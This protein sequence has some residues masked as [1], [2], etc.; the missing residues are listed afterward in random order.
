[1][2]EDL[3][4][5]LFAANLG[6]LDL[7]SI[8]IG[9][10]LG[11]YRSLA[12][13]GPATPTE[14]ATR[15]G[16]HERYAREWLEQQAATAILTVDDPGGDA[17]E[18]RYALPSAHADLLLNKDNLDFAIGA[19]L[20]GALVAASSA[21]PQVLDAFRTGGGVPWGAYGSRLRDGEANF[22]RGLYL[23]VLCQ[24]YFPL[25]PDAHERLRSQPPARVADLGCGSGWS[26]IAIARGYPGCLVD[27]FDLD[28]ASVSLARKNASEAGVSDRVRFE[29][30]DASDPSLGAAPA[31]RGAYDVVTIF[32]ALHDMSGPV[33]ALVN[34]R[35]MLA[36]G[37]TAIVMDERVGEEFT[38]PADDV[39]RFMYGWSILVCLP[40]GMSQPP[41][42]GTGT[43][44]R[45]ATLRKYAAKAGFRDVVILPIENDFFRFYRLVA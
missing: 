2:G 6:A 42:A 34:V 44:M 41:A 14:L 23:N 5:R 45:P 29:V 1:M 38:A 10:Q 28:Q 26:S 8:H 25:I 43:V 16:T 11:F 15:T 9:D 37:G 13:D 18:R 3:V 30:A 19:P 22:N 4:S 24:D 12:D 7:L 35:A 20:A 27:G 39:E 21:I 33:E 32:E 31:R 40:G 17:S 36:P